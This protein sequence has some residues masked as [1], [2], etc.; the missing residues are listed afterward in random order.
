M[1]VTNYYSIGGEILGEGDGANGRDYL[2]DAQGNLTGMQNVSGIVST[3]Y[4]PFGRGA[5]PSGS[6][7]GWL[8]AAGYRPT[9]LQ[10]STH[11]VRARHY[12]SAQA[13]WLSV[14]LLWP[15]ETPYTYADN[16]PVLRV[17]PSGLA[18]CPMWLAALIGGISCGSVSVSTWDICDRCGGGLGGWC[19]C[20][21]SLD[22][23]LCISGTY[24]GNLYKNCEVTSC[25]P[26]SECS[27]GPFQHL[28]S[29]KHCRCKDRGSC[30]LTGQIKL[31]NK[32]VTISTGVITGTE[33]ISW[34]ESKSPVTL[35]LC[36]I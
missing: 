10:P 23:Q 35:L 5:A 13:R 2:P 3:S 34:S 22:Y 9:G 4:S 15:H 32:T 36:D 7:M 6:T 18:P 29:C 14:D 33:T 11:Y 8:G 1:P 12:S 31:P 27:T 20:E 21:G 28:A 16:A 24:I 17:D 25:T 30:P 26:K 19:A